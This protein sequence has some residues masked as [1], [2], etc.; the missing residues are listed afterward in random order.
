MKAI[1]G[2]GVIIISSTMPDVAILL[3]IRQAVAVGKPFKV[4]QT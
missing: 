2:E 4:I 1:A 3:A